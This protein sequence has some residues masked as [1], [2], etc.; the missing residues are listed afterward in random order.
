MDP[1][2][3]SVKQGKSAQLNLRGITLAMYVNASWISY[4]T[5]KCGPL[6]LVE[7]QKDI[8][9]GLSST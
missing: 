3:H 6:Q 9:P 1:G 7:L 2:N 4:F 5:F 8:N